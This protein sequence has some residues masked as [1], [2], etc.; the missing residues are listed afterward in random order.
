MAALRKDLSPRSPA[1]QHKTSMWLA[2]FGPY[3]KLVYLLSNHCFGKSHV[4]EIMA[5]T[6]IIVRL[7]C[8]W[9]GFEYS[10]KLRLRKYDPKLLNTPKTQ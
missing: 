8:L 9:V 6:I 5:I 3:H 10:S 7:Y 4:K 2:L 1:A